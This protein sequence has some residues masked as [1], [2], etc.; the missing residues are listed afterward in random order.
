MEL[1]IIF[2]GLYFLFILFIVVFVLTML[3][4]MTHAQEAMHKHLLEIARCLKEQTRI[5]S[6]NSRETS[7]PPNKSA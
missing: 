2:A 3:Y 6:E 5:Q 4:R 1:G 7:G